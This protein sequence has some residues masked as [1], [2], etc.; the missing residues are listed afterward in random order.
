MVK[1][2]GWKNLQSPKHWEI[3]HIPPQQETYFV[4]T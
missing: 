1:Y 4:G 3:S 2:Y